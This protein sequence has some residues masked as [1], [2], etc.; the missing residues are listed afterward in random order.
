MAKERGKEKVMGVLRPVPRFSKTGLHVRVMF[1][2]LQKLRRKA[3]DNQCSRIGFAV[4]VRSS[5]N[6]FGVNYKLIGA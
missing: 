1:G 3:V 6:T 4:F 5:Q 2:K